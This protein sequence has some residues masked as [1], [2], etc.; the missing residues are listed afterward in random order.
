[1]F[2]AEKNYSILKNK[3]LVCFQNLVES[4]ALT[5]EHQVTIKSDIPIMSWLL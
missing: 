1:M 4:E 2:S 3:L 5:I